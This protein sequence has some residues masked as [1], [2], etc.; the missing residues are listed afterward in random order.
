MVASTVS[1]NSSA[2]TG[3]GIAVTSTA[4]GSTV[5]VGASIVAGNTATGGGPDCSGTGLSSDGYDLT[6]DAVGTTCGMSPA[7]HDVIDAQPDLGSLANNGGPTQTLLPAETSPAVGQVPV[8]T[9]LDGVAACPGTD[10]RGVSRPQPSD[11]HFCTIGAVEVTNPAPPTITTA[12]TTT[13]TAGVAST[14]PVAVIGYPGAAFALSAAPPWL[15]IGPSSG[16]L[17]GIPPTTAGGSYTFTVV[18]TDG[19]APAAVQTF[20]LT[21]DE[22]P[23]VTSQPAATATPA[24]AFSF[25][26][27]AS[28]Y[29]APTFALS[30]APSWLSIGP[31]TGILSGTPPTGA[32]SSTF[33]ISATNGVGAPAR[34]TFTLHLGTTFAYWEVAADGGIFTFG[35]AHFFGSMGGKPLNAPV[36]GM[37]ATPTGGGYWEVAA[38][39]GIFT[40]G[41]AGFYGS[42]GGKPLDA[43]VVGMA[44]APTG[45][46]YW[47]VAA[48][49][50]VFAFGSAQNLGGE[51]GRVLAAPVVGIAPGR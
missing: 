28:G 36:V 41:S 18:A 44:A 10:Q 16:I 26:V 40:F 38:D 45:K 17:S 1:G 14:F 4:T 24:T 21:V 51:G 27:T 25:Q 20:T 43:P 35:H 11:S 15:T 7:T 2:G 8:A 30:G 42:M 50:N 6:S 29:P 31:T 37:A 47:E 19:V 22:A 13:F 48:D 5:H 32:T 3:G 39:G 34:Q 9:T 12:D 49:G 46:G 33:T 23:S